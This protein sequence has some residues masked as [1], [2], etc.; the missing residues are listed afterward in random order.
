[1]RI[2][3]T[4]L[5]E[6]TFLF[7][8]GRPSDLRPVSMPTDYS[9]MGESKEPNMYKRGSRDSENSLLHYL[10]DDKILVIQEEPVNQREGKRE[11]GHRSRKKN[12]NPSSPNFPISPTLLTSTVRLEPSQQD[13]VN[14]ALAESNTVPLYHIKELVKQE[15]SEE[16]LQHN[17][18][19]EPSVGDQYESVVEVTQQRKEK[20]TVESLTA[21]NVVE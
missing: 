2:Q 7:L 20:K 6:R 12:K 8:L 19:L 15:A 16:D 13:I 10:S 9:W 11:T 3:K 14:F 5:Y 1:M 18:A 21:G 4:C 17:D